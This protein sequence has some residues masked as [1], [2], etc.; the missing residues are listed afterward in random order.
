MAMNAKLMNLKLF[1]PIIALLAI[2]SVSAAV[3]AINGMIENVFNIITAFEVNSPAA[4]LVWVNILFVILKC[5]D[6]IIKWR[7]RDGADR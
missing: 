4:L 1:E 5:V 3:L 6:I 2:P 7:R